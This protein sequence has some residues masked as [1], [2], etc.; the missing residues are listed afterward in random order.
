MFCFCA[1]CLPLAL[2]IL[3]H[4]RASRAAA[5]RNVTAR[6]FVVFYL[7]GYIVFTRPDIRKPVTP[8]ASHRLTSGDTTAEGIQHYGTSKRLFCVGFIFINFH[9]AKQRAPTL[10]KDASIKADREDHESD[11][12]SGPNVSHFITSKCIVQ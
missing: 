7:H 6:D 10:G 12:K 1:C 8:S 4:V 2:S 5:Y 11:L 9:I 3:S